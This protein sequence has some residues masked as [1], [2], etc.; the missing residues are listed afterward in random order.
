MKKISKGTK[1]TKKIE[2][3][4]TQE[5][6]KDNGTEEVVISEKNVATKKGKK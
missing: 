1:D 5:E 2:E 4:T 3:V 6:L